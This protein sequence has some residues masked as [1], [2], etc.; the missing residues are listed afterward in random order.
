MSTKEIQEKLVQNMKDW[1]AIEKQSI[2]STAKIMNKTDNPVVTHIAE[3]IQN[4]SNR[5][6]RIQRLIVNSLEEKALS[7]TP[8]ELGEIWGYIE[9]HIELEKK[10]IQYAKDSLS[11]LKGK[12]MVIQEYLLNYLLIDEEKHDIMLESLGKIKSGMYPYG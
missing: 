2:L 8:E 7:L 11:L 12:K 9:E 6:F 1:Q 4:D 10:T 3:I 5:H